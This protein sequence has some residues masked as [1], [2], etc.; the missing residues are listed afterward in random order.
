MTS[1]V[2][3]HA[4][5]TPALLCSRAITAVISIILDPLRMFILLSYSRLLQM[6]HKNSLTLSQ[7][8]NRFY[9]CSVIVGFSADTGLYATY[10]PIHPTLL[11]AF[12]VTILHF[13]SPRL[14][15]EVLLFISKRL[16]ISW[17]I[18]FTSQESLCISV[19]PLHAGLFFITWWWCFS[20]VTNASWHQQFCCVLWML[21]S[22][23]NAGLCF[24]LSCWF[25]FGST[26]HIFN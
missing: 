24:P 23:I 20:G 26:S 2:F 19:F 11:P 7:A 6:F 12:F 22:S 5:S 18:S 15:I 14:L 10:L 17:Q 13:H 9:F 16:Q 4:A 1:L 8:E 25:H 3:F 21:A